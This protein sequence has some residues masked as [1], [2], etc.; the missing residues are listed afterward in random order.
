MFFSIIVPVYKVEQYLSQC[1]DSVLSQSF[2]DY[3]LI[4]IDDGSP[5]GCPQICD[6]YQ[7]SNKKVKVIHQQNKGI[8]AARNAGLNVAKGKYVLFLDSDDFWED[9]DALKKVYEICIQNYVDYVGF[10]CKNYNV[11]TK[12]VILDDRIARGNDE[13][14]Y[15]QEQVLRYFISMGNFPGAAWI[16]AVS[17]T[18][19]ENHHIRFTEGIKSEDID[20][21]MQVFLYATTYAFLDEYFYVYRLNRDGS[22]TNTTDLKSVC[23]LIGII[24]RWEKELQNPKYNSVKG[25][26]ND[27][28]AYHYLCTLILYADLSRKN[29]KKV[30]KQIQ[31]NKKILCKELYRRKVRTA[32][33]I[34]KIGGLEI[35]SLILKLYH[36]AR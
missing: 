26:L 7:K 20:W 17:K 23:D 5:D 25:Y 11:K 22:I 2:A 24:E 34:Y 19:I 16:S 35:S 14:I 12:E 32:A 27:Y 31:N 18:F 15:S 8:S 28:L 29:K 33:M 1:V 6:E 30:A 13:N 36:G 9:V 10:N 3:E 21:L 4:L